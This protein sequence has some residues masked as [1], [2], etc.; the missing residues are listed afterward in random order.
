M[1]GIVHELPLPISE[2]KL[3]G[4]DPEN[5]EALSHDCAYDFSPE[6]WMEIYRMVQEEYLLAETAEGEGAGWYKSVA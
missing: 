5:P 1:Q 3:T 4:D 6:H 2:T